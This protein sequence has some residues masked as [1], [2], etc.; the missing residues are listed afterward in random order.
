MARRGRKENALS[1]PGRGRGPAAGGEG[2]GRSAHGSPNPCITP[3]PSHAAHGPLP[4]PGAGEGARSGLKGAPHLYSGPLYAGLT[5]GILGGSFNPA[6]AGH[7]HISLF[8]L[9]ALGLDR[10]WWMVSPQNPLKSASGMA[11]LAERLAEARAVAAHPRIEVTAIETAL[12]TRFTADTLAKLQRRF[13][14]TRFVWLMGAD[15]L[16]QIPRWKLWTRIFDSVAVAV[17]ARPT[18]SL[19]ALSGKAAHRFTRRR[20]SVSGVKGLARRRRPAWAFLR[21]PLHPASATAIRQA[22]AAGS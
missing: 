5:V 14:K 19:S 21:N 4:S 1:R 10:V 22:R 11:S 6:H 12:G 3:H 8:A 9:K 16:R 15:N 2:E 20:V 18:Y 17:F 13:P 7:R